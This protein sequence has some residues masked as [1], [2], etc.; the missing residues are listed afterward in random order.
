MTLEMELGVTGGEEDGI[1][2]TEVDNADLY[3]QPEEVA[4]A[5]EELIKFQINLQLQ[6]HLEMYMVYTNQEMF[7]SLLRF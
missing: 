3:T 6:L 7:N 1:D 5:Y 2:N 4:Y